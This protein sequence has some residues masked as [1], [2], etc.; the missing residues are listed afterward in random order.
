MTHLPSDLYA[1]AL[2]QDREAEISR[3][4]RR[5]AWARIQHARHRDAV[6]RPEVS[7]R[8]TILA[9]VV[10]LVPPLRRG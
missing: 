10:G 2:M 7:Q 1:P 3:A 6:R 8:R 4:A 5:P 9:R